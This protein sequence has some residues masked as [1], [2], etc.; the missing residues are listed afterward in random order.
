MAKKVK[1]VDEKQHDDLDEFGLI[2]HVAAPVKPANVKPND[3]SVFLGEHFPTQEMSDAMLGA[4]EILGLAGSTEIKSSSSFQA[5]LAAHLARRTPSMQR[6]PLTKKRRWSIAFGPVTVPPLT[7]ITAEAQPRVLYRGERFINTGDVTDLFMTS[8]YVGSKSQ[9]PASNFS[10]IPIKAFSPGALPNGLMTLDTCEPESAI[11][12]QIQ[13]V[14]N[15]AR[16]W[17]MTLFGIVVQ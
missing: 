16:T 7:T 3:S 5:A 4:Q 6:V 17:A 2:E 1:S 13:N 12:V 8:L 14:G 9:F 11:A 10:G 15:V